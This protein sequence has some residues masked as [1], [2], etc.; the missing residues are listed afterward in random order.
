MPNALAAEKSPY[1]RQHANN[2]VDWLPWGE[3]A[4][5]RARAE[6]KPIFL[7]IGYSTCHWCH[8]MAHESFEDADIAA[9]LNKD[10][11]AIKV[12]REERPDVD[13]VYMAYVQAMTGHGGWPLSAWLTPELKPFF[14]G[15]YFPPEDR[16]GR[17]GFPTLLRA[18]AKGWETEREKLVA[19]GDRALGTLREYY[20]RPPAAEGEVP[21]LTLSGGEAFE[22]CFQYFYEAFDPQAGGFGGAPK[23]PRA[24]NLNFLFRA[25]AVQGVT[26]EVGTEAIK[27]AT[28]TLREMAKGGLHDHV[29]GGFHR[30]SVD[31]KWFVPHFEKM[32]YDQAQ[33]AVNFLA[34][35]QASGVE[36]YGWLARD[37]LDYV[38]RELTHPAGGFYTAED[39]DSVVAHGRPEHAEGAYYVWGA[40]ELQAALGDDY[41]FFAAHYGVQAEGNVAAALDPQGEFRGK[42]ILAQRTALAVTAQ[43]FGLAPAAADAKVLALLGRLL[44]L[45]AGRPRPH[46]DNKILT[47][48]NGLMISAFAKAAQVLEKT[49]A[50][51]ADRSESGPYLKAATR[52]AEFVER[53][54]YDASSGVL[55]RSWLD[56]RGATLA[57]AEDYAFLIQGLLDLYEAAF[58]V[59]WLQWAVELQ[60]AMDREF[61]DEVGGGYFNSRA[62][63]ASLVLRL[64]EDYDG[65]E[66]APGSVAAMN[67]LRLEAMLGHE[68]GAWRAQALRT[69]ESL[70]PQWSK[71]PQ[72]LPQLLCAVELA[73]EPPRHVVLA[74]DPAAADFRALAAVLQERLGPHRVLL[75]ADGGAGQRWLAERAPW[76][77]EMRPIHGR[78]AAYLCENFTCQSPVTEPAA[79]RELLSAGK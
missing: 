15:T 57:F 3:V 55:Y 48:N 69:I 66:P 46:L 2:P 37:I 71:A 14:G 6:Q 42:N 78:A 79:L 32:L 40:A 13:K 63:D 1:L 22:K 39:A 44:T 58:A 10:F 38:L 34:A 19:E 76:L 64:K 29:G 60:A 77:A 20:E 70:R 43:A 72:A 7:S 24:A 12:D 47:A 9:L 23:F 33:I 51:G 54:L 4:F 68:S 17:P 30:Y 36:T 73:L 65:A 26:S 50:A 41:A 59:H 5:A 49:G 21:D 35:Q 11:V 61:W 56:G 27:L 62:D 18:I 8:V 31:E 52:A 25:A 67:L 16:H 45:R 75:A 74:G 28:A 53:E